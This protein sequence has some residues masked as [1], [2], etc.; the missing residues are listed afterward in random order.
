MAAQH[1]IQANALDAI[2]I[3][4]WRLQGAKALLSEGKTVEALAELHEAE[5]SV[6]HNAIPQTVTYARAAE[7]T[8]WEA[9][10]RAIGMT[11]QSAHERFAR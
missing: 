5:M 11:R 8:P 6:R 10:G 9:I 7:A 3:V 1:I 2:E 4:E